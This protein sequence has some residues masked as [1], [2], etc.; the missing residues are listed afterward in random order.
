MKLVTAYNEHPAEELFREIDAAELAAIIR[1][2]RQDAELSDADY[3]IRYPHR[4]W[5]N[6][7]DDLTDAVST[8]HM[9]AEGARIYM[10]RDEEGFYFG[11]EEVAK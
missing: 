6:A 8:V 7:T 2:L 10:A 3:Y 5:N 1:V 4:K 9:A 11:V